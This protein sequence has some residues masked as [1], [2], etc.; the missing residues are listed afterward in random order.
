MAIIHHLL[1]TNNKYY[2]IGVHPTCEVYLQRQF[3]NMPFGWLTMHD[4]HKCGHVINVNHARLKV[5]SHLL[6]S[7]NL[8]NFLNINIVVT[9]T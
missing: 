6:L 2:V 3:A 8:L 5:D 1:T 7:D 4:N 9:L